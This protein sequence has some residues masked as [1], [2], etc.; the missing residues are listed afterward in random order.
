MTADVLLRIVLGFFIGVMFYYIVMKP[1]LKNVNWKLKK[2][3]RI[4][5]EA[6]LTVETPIKDSNLT[7]E[8]LNLIN[9]DKE[10]SEEDIWKYYQMYC[11]K[12]EMDNKDVW[13]TLHPKPFE[14]WEKYAKT[15]TKRIEPKGE[16][17]GFFV[18]GGYFFMIASTCD[19][20]VGIPPNQVY[21]RFNDYAKM[22]EVDNDEYL[23][24]LENTNV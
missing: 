19:A 8:E 11:K 2:R 10:P 24:E 13:T 5:R 7:Q 17:F 12:F 4:L 22:V 20:M 15:P 16:G 9:S 1:I 6:G 23:E 3:I 14:Q 21:M 18:A